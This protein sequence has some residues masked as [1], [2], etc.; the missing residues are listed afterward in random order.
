MNFKIKEKFLSYPTHVQD[1]VSELRDLIFKVAQLESIE[2]EESLKWNEL[3]YRPVR[4]KVGTTV[5]IDW[6]KHSP[7]K[8]FLFFSCNTNLVDTFRVKYRELLFLKNRAIVL[9]LDKDLPKKILAECI[10]SAFT[11]FLY[12]KG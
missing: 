4:G 8:L 1:K 3:G 6:K 9:V 7:D 11:Y 5:R 2:I 10:A 12:K